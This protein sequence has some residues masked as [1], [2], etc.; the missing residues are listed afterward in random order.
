MYQFPKPELFDFKC[1]LRRTWTRKY[2]KTIGTFVSG[3][4]RFENPFH[5][6]RIYRK[7]KHSSMNC[8]I[9]D[10]EPLARVEMQSLIQEISKVEVLASFSNAFTALDFLKTNQVDLIF[11]DIQMPLM[12]GLEFA[13]SLPKQS[14]I[15]FTT[16]YSQ[17]ALKSYDLDAID[18][19]LKPIE[20]QRLEK[21]INKAELYNQLLSQE[22]IIYTVESNTRDFL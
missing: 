9:I 21:A 13:E 14:L 2:Q 16:A 22:T 6:S 11:L 8:I 10:D 5:Q 20:K 15:I 19:L 7:P 18:Y 12:T 3:Q 17:Y 4:I 1:K